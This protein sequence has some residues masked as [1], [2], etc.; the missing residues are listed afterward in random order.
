MYLGGKDAD[1]LNHFEALDKKKDLPSF[2]ALHESARRLFQRYGHPH[3]FDNIIQGRFKSSETTIPPGDVWTPNTT[4]KSSATLNN[5][6]GSKKVKRKAKKVKKSEDDSDEDLEI[7]FQGD[8][9]LAQS[10]R[11]MYDTTISREVIYATAEGDVGRIWEALKVCV[12]VLIYA[13]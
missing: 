7:P 10:C 1:L 2:E 9:S 4:D 6:S 5:D 13:V 3:T 11:F 8:Q 12:Q